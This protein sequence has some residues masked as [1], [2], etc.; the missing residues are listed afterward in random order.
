LPKSILLVEDDEELTRIFV[1]LL[2]RKGLDV[3]SYLSPIQALENFKM[4]IDRYS[5]VLTD[6]KME[7]MNGIEFAQEI[8][9]LKGNDIVIIMI[10]A[11]SLQD[12]ENKEEIPTLID[13]AITKPFSLKSLD[14]I[15]SSYLAIHP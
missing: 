2:K 5:L 10:T 3:V 13:K 9:R 14:A 8:R 12:I 7:G 11:F 1:T 6:H 15:L 4:N